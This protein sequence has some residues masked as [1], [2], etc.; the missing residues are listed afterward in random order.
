MQK[1]C[2]EINNEVY[3]F[4]KLK[5]N[6][7]IKLYSENASYFKIPYECNDLEKKFIK[8]IFLNISILENEENMVDQEMQLIAKI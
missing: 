3:Q 6:S 2:V 8:N 4:S 5:F 1:I 7:G